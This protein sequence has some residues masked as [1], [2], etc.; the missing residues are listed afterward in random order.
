[1]TLTA[2]LVAV[3]SNGTMVNDPSVQQIKLAS[4]IHV[5]AFS[6]HGDL[7]AVESE[8]DFTIDIWEEVNQRAKLVCHGGGGMRAKAKT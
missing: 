1:M 6:S 5:L 3:S 2:T 8:G 4:S 7:L